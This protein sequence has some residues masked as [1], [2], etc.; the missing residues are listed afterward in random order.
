MILVVSMILGMLGGL[1]GLMVEVG[2]LDRLGMKAPVPPVAETDFILLSACAL[3]CILGGAMVASRRIL[4]NMYW[5]EVGALLMLGGGPI[6]G[7]Y[8]GLASL[9][10]IPVFLTV[11]GALLALLVADNYPRLTAA[12]EE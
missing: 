4:G 6:M 9:S 11:I 10:S 7:I 1:L 8:L 5:T 12:A 3:A 2:M